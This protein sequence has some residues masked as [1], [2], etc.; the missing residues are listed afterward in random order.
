MRYWDTGDEATNANLTYLRS[1]AL[2]SKPPFDLNRVNDKFIA[3]IGVIEML[4]VK[5][6][7]HFDFPQLYIGGSAEWWSAERRNTEAARLC[8][9]LTT[10]L[11]RIAS[12][13]TLRKGGGADLRDRKKSQGEAIL[14][15]LEAF[16]AVFPNRSYSAEL[17]A[18]RQATLG[19]SLQW[20]VTEIERVLNKSRWN[21]PTTRE[22][23]VY[24][25][26]GAIEFH[27]AHYYR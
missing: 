4:P 14:A 27:A 21:G 17:S 9:A 12:D 25:E 24:R 7:Q 8:D 5:V 11:D 1:I 3:V 2:D 23:E 10:G 13:P 6:R 20:R 26:L 19:T 15:A 22:Y 16:K 18:L